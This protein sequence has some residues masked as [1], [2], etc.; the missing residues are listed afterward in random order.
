MHRPRQR[1]Q[2]RTLLARLLEQLVRPHR[3]ALKRAAGPARSSSLA[4]QPGQRQRAKQVHG[5][6]CI[7]RRGHADLFASA[8]TRY[9]LTRWL[10]TRAKKDIP[11]SSQVCRRSAPST[12]VAFTPPVHL[13][14]RQQ[15]TT[16]P[17]LSAGRVIAHLCIGCALTGKKVMAVPHTL[18]SGGTVP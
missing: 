7:R 1:R 13:P 12:A 2:G 11:Q 8:S 18:L 4:W 15:R 6:S 16:A 17:S 14:S 5:A 9:W 3:K 10:S